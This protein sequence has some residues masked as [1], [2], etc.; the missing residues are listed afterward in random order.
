M[1]QG[2]KNLT[3]EA[4]GT[5]LINLLQNKSPGGCWFEETWQ[6]NMLAAIGGW[7]ASILIQKS[8]VK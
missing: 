6:R 2:A 3:E 8:N 1:V 7:P 5:F 4:L